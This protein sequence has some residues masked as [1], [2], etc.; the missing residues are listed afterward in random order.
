MLSSAHRVRSGILLGL[1]TLLLAGCDDDPFAQEWFEN[2]TQ[3]TVYAL[4]HP[5]EVSPT[6]WD[7]LPRQG[8]RIEDPRTED[9]WDFA[10]DVDGGTMYLLPPRALGV[11]SRVGIHRVPDV[12][13]DDVREAPADTAAYVTREP[14]EVGEDDIYVVRTREQTDQFG[15]RC[16]FY[17]KVQPEEVDTDRLRLRFTFDVNPG[18]NDRNLVPEEI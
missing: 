18:C 8:R 10:V 17:A 2:R 15:R 4:D 6:A 9:D 14:V 13:W 11:S 1:G 3:T 16:I 5:D 7:L 12:E